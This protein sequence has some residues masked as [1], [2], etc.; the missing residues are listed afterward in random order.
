MPNLSKQAKYRIL[1]LIGSFML[2]TSLF[3]PYADGSTLIAT[4]QPYLFKMF[5][6]FGDPT[7]ENF[8]FTASAIGFILLVVGGVMCLVFSAFAYKGSRLWDAPKGIGIWNAAIL[9]LFGVILL[10]APILFY[11]NGDLVAVR[12]VTGIQY[13]PNFE[14]SDSGYYINWVGVLISV[15]SGNLILRH[16]PASGR[17]FEFF[18]K[19][20]NGGIPDSFSV[21]ITGEPGSGKSVLCQQLVYTFLTGGS[22]CTYVTYD[23][24]PHEIRE[25]IEKFHWNISRYEDEGKLKFVDC[26][27][28]IAKVATRE[29]YS[30]DDPFSLTQLGIVMSDAADEVNPRVLLDSIVPLV[31]NVNPT[32]VVKFLQ[33]RISRIKGSNGVFTFTAG[34]KTIKPRLMSQLQETVD[35][36]IEL[37][38]SG[39]Q[40]N[41]VRRLRV[42]KM[43]GRKIPKKW[44]QFEI[45]SK[46][47]IIFLV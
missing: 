19:M 24:F 20:T 34:A 30:T 12:S 41:I 3:L 39:D 33:E 21:L 28:P 29:K 45:D 23:W 47:G 43:R 18:R 44:F 35:C 6:V 5:D 38:T 8:S 22:T 36:I 11:Q 31:T 15:V 27:S 9:S 32:M 13:S 2:L 10:S 25:S 4:I 37:D 17:T 14:G 26:V 42:R 16:K 7:L 40:N 1:W 46:R